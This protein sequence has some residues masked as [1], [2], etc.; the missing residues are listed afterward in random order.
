MHRNC[1]EI[2]VNADDLILEEFKSNW[3]YLKH[4]EEIRLKLY[5]LYVTIAAALL[6]VLAAI[7]KIGDTSSSEGA[8]AQ[9][10]VSLM[11]IS[12]FLATY[13][14]LF[15]WLILNQKTSYEK[16]REKNI[17]IRNLFYSRER[18]SLSSSFLDAVEK[19]KPPASGLRISSTFIAWVSLPLFISLVSTVTF[20]WTVCNV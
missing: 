5:Q 17:E 18:E 1:G 9:F 19:I 11:F 6:S 3:A 13:G 15:I 20:V 8:T 7:Y 4:I 12:G 16:Y 10:N 2:Q 14:F